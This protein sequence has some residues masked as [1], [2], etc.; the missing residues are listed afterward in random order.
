MAF[1]ALAFLSHPMAL[2]ALAKQAQLSHPMG[3]GVH[4]VGTALTPSGVHCTGNSLTPS[5]VHCAG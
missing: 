1:T 3:H 2:T 4:C 5:G